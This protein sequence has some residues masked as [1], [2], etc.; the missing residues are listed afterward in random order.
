MLPHNR[1]IRAVV[2][3]DTVQGCAKIAEA[4]LVHG[5]DM[6]WFVRL[7]DLTGT[8]RLVEQLFEKSGAELR[9]V[10]RRPF[11]SAP[12]TIEWHGV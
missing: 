10:H 8:G 5:N 6:E 3:D 1:E 9:C 2:V 7:E 4:A 12:G 11:T